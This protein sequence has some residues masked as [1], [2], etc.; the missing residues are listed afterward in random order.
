MIISGVTYS[1]IPSSTN[2][3]ELLILKFKATIKMDQDVYL[4]KKIKIPADF[5]EKYAIIRYR[6]QGYYKSVKLT[7]IDVD[8]DKENYSYLE[9]SKEIENAN[10]IELIFLIRGKKY[11]INLK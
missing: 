3:S 5:F 2:R 7:K 10:K 9:V 4:A 8:Y 6:Y 1:I 11:T